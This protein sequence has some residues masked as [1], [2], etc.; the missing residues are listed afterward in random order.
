[1]QNPVL[2]ACILAASWVRAAHV[3][4]LQN[5]A[6]GLENEQSLL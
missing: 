3:T 6:R 2:I 5:L 4:Y 1:V